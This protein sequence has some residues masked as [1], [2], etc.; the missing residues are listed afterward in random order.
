MKE[1]MLRR[2]HSAPLKEVADSQPSGHPAFI[3]TTARTEVVDHKDSGLEASPRKKIRTVRSDE[4][5]IPLDFPVAGSGKQLTCVYTINLKL[6][7]PI[8]GEQMIQSWLWIP[9]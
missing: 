2:R 6:I 4:P 8:V 3:D 9:L 1:V 7:A 5:I